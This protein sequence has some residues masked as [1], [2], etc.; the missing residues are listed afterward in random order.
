MK[1]NT[2][3]LLPPFNKLI[4]MTAWRAGRRRQRLLA[5]RL[6]PPLTD[7]PSPYMHN[8]R[9]ITQLQK[10]KCRDGGQAIAAGREVTAG[11]HLLQRSSTNF[12][13]RRRGCEAGLKPSHCL[14]R[15]GKQIR[16]RLASGGVAQHT[17]WEEGP[18]SHDRR[19]QLRTKP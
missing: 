15:G 16:Q 19:I 12:V 14:H 7:S 3:S 1:T 8:F 9:G 2:T 11:S 5:A 18:M 10:T 4:H 13:G 17:G 6:M